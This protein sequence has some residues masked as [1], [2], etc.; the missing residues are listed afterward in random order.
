[1]GAGSHGR[2]RVHTVPRRSLALIATGPAT[3][4]LET[5]Q[6]FPF[7]A[8]GDRLEEEQKQGCE[9]FMLELSWAAGGEDRPKKKLVGFSGGPGEWGAAVSAAPACWLMG[10]GGWSPEERVDLRP[11]TRSRERGV[12]PPQ[13]GHRYLKGLGETWR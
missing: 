3:P 10:L 1:M 9:G 4:S 11:H 12:E 8:T 2:R 6:Q 5:C 7:L 13:R